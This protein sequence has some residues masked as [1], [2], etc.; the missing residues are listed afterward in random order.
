M[1]GRAI[2]G[3]FPWS[4]FENFDTDLAKRGQFQKLKNHEGDLSPNFLKQTGDYWLVTSNQQALWIGAN[5]F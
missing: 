2:W 5:A 3:K 4:I 1:F